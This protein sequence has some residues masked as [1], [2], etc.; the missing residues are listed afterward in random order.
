MGRP[1]TV[2]ALIAA[3][4]AYA[5]TYPSNLP[6]DA[7][8]RATPNDPVAKLVHDNIKLETREGFGL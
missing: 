3:G 8:R 2:A 6:A 7:Y 4:I 5:Q 1:R